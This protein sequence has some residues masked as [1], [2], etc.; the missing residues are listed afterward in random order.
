MRRSVAHC[1]TGKAWGSLQNPIWKQTAESSI[2]VNNVLSEIMHLVSSLKAVAKASIEP[3]YR[4]VSAPAA[5]FLI[6]LTVLTFY[7]GY[8]LMLVC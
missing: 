1:K 6:Q 8:N 4:K 7:C 3:S 5:A 2:T